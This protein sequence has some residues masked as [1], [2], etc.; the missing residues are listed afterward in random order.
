MFFYILTIIILFII[1][2][3]V[4]NKKLQKEYFSNC[5]NSF[6]ILN[7]ESNKCECK[8]QKDDLR[9]IFDSPGKCCDDMCSKKSPENCHETNDFYQAPYY[10]NM[11]GKCK[12]YD[13]T[14][15]SS[16]ISANYC[17]NDPLN[18]QILLPYASLEECSA[19]IEPCDKYNI[20][21]RSEHVNKNV[22]LKDVNCGWCNNKSG[23]GKCISGNAS[24]PND[25]NKYFYC[26]PADVSGSNSYEYGNHVAYLLQK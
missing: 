26:K 6:C 14:I 12:K 23:G 2:F 15:R 17:G 16:H 13:G 18:N 24:G 10:C 22:C 5:K 4:N 8:N 21:D 7:V 20:M 1:L 11:G 9:Y 3:I 19:N 25:L